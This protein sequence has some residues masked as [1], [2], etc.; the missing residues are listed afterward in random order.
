MSL[1]KARDD[2]AALAAHFAVL[3]RGGAVLTNTRQAGG[4]RATW[5]LLVKTLAGPVAWP[6]RDRDLSLFDRVIR[7]DPGDPRADGLADAVAYRND[8]LRALTEAAWSGRVGT[9]TRGSERGTG[10]P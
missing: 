9:F 4:D 8:R 7:V 2:L 1:A 5:M 10:P 3:Y 6:V